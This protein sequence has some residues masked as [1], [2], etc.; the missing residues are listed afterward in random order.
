MNWYKKLIFANDD[1]SS[2]SSYLNSIGVIPEV[3]NFILSIPD[4]KNKQFYINKARTNPSISLEEIKKQSIPNKID[5][6]LDSE[7]TI[8][9][10]FREYQEIPN[11]SKWI[12]VNLRKIRKGLA[13]IKNNALY[14]PENNPL[15]TESDYNLYNI[16]SEKVA[17]IFD[18]IKNT[19]IDIS[20]FSAENAIKMS[21][22]W[23]KEM[24]EKGEG[25]KYDTMYPKNLI[26]GPDWKNKEFNGWTI[27]RVTTKNDLLTEGNK[28]DHCVG[29]FCENVFDR[30]SVIFSLR[31]PQN[32]PHVTI[33][34]DGEQ[35]Y[36]MGYIEQIK[37]KSNSEPKPIYKEMI[38]EW[39]ES[40]KSNLEIQN[41]VEISEDLD[42]IWIN[43]INDKLEDVIYGKTNEYG[44][45]YVLDKSAIDLMEEMLDKAESENSRP[46]RGYDGDDYYYGS[47]VDSTHIIVKLAIIEDLKIPYFPTNKKEFE[48]LKDKRNSS[49]WENIYNLIEK[50]YDYISSIQEDFMG[51]ETGLEYPSE[52]NYETP[53]EYNN[54]IEEFEKEESEIHN[55]W[56]KLSIKGGFSLDVLDDI[57]DYIKLGIIPSIEEIY[58]LNKVLKKQNH[59][60]L[61]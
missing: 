46:Q 33:E 28:M 7:K 19:N 38:K 10:E 15:L 2:I 21:D 55:N 25:K 61:V 9:Y 18:W 14:F 45:K 29:S 17:E 42:N 59:Y 4:K 50:S 27:Q 40:G 47:I 41:K 36:D 16:F 20:S 6:Y 26:Y 8:A 52:E 57:Q 32:E 24:V 5:P 39:I 11:F 31:D 53:E 37:G 3:V 35:G 22:Q 54:A 60:E 49:K 51:Y 48:N 44:L 56:T 58:N 23:H 13:N 12:L 34:V 1:N 43:E 30:R